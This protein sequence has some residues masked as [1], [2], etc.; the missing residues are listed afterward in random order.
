MCLWF[1]TL[2]GLIMGGGV[3]AHGCDI[4]HYCPK[5]TPV[6]GFPDAFVPIK[7]VPLKDIEGHQSD[8]LTGAH[9]RRG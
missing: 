5:K 9:H 4:P 6:C 7:H 3:S 1:Q 8:T 2:S